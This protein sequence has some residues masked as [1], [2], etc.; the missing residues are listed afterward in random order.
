LIAEE[1]DESYL[2]FSNSRDSPIAIKITDGTFT[3]EEDAI[4][5]VISKINFDVK[6]GEL[7]AVVGAV[8]SG[9][10]TLLLRHFWLLWYIN[11]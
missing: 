5:P 9:K 6:K 8:G 2:K 7:F 1:I 11:D 10:S 4:L 3:W